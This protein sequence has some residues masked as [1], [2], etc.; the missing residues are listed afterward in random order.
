M[1]SSFNT[2]QWSLIIK[3]RSDDPTEARAAT[4]A[5]C[6][7]YWLPI[8]AW[9]RSSGNPEEPAKD[10]TQGFFLYAIRKDLLRKADAR[11]G[12]LRTFLLTSL[13]H[14]LADEQERAS[15]RKREGRRREIPLD[16]M[17]C[18]AGER[19]IEHDLKSDDRTPS[20]IY[21]YRWART[22]LQISLTRLESE[23]RDKG[24]EEMFRV[25]APLLSD[26]EKKNTYSDAA[27]RLKCSEGA[28]R[29]AF[30]RFKKRFRDILREEVARTLLPDETIDE[31][32]SELSAILAGKGRHEKSFHS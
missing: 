9:L 30:H 19:G 29:V 17:N 4:E 25:L 20:E 3:I 27:G 5:I 16:F 2:T 10:F 13:K 23:F 28:V 22:L 8:Y 6:Q 14:F 1:S 26:L 21:D 31:E 15:A 11:K 18:E 32:M 24:K 12:K 7:S